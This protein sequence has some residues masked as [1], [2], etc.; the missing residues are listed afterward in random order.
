MRPTHNQA[1]ACPVWSLIGKCVCVCVA[2]RN[3]LSYGWRWC[4]LWQVAWVTKSGGADLAEP[5]AIRP[6]SETIMYPAY[7]KWIHSHR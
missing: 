1:L 4:C 7:S 5:V 2:S 3:P 6:T